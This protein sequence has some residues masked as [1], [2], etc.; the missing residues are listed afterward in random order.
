M[1]KIRWSDFSLVSKIMIEVGVLAVLLFSINM[2]F[3]ARINNSMQEMDDVYA[4]NAQITELGQVFDDVQDSMYQ[5]LKVKNSQALMDYYQNEAKYRQELEKLNERNI[6]DSVKLLEKKI[7]KMSESYLYCTAGTVAAKRG[8]NV[9]KYKQEYDESLELY[10][11][12]QSSMDELNKQLFKENSQTYAALRAVMRYLEISNMM[13]MLL[14]VICGMFLLIMATREMFLP[15]TN[16]A[17]TAQ[18]VGQGNFNVKMPPA[19]S[20]D[21]LGTVTRA[22]NTMVDNLGLY[23]AR[24]KASMEKE[25]QMIERE[26]LMETHLKEAQLKYLQS[27]INPHFLF[28]TLNMIAGTAQIEDAAATEK[29]IHALSR[30]FRYNLKSAASVMPL[31]R[32]LRVVQDYMY[33]QQMRFGKRIQYF[34]DCSPETLEILVPSFMLQPLV[35]NA[36]KHG[37]STRSKGGKILVRSW[38]DKQRLWISV[39]DTGEGMESEK[40]EAIKRALT[41]GN[42]QGT[43]IGVGN[44]YRRIHTMYR[45]G[46]M[47]LYSRRGCGTVVQLVFTPE[48]YKEENSESGK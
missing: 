18:L 36:V 12:I 16:M 4:S 10:S 2:L 47:F 24:T 17:E 1:K 42:E 41:E 6:D 37:L 22:F 26:L 44:I 34:T 28:N 48:H 45:D 5:Y 27:Q 35:E 11:Y 13:I 23:I 30:L 31:E 39:A 20:R 38:K 15:L 14:V 46:E 43:G 32:E 33:L 29:M 7:R 40:L 3:Y 9:E 25:Q 19:D 21:E 8:R